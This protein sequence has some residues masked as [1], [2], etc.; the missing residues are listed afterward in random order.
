V[1][2]PA[3]GA[4]VPDLYVLAERWDRVVGELRRAGR[5]VL[6][7]LLAQSAPV[8]VAASGAVTIEPE[9]AGAA[10]PLEAARDDIVAALQQQF[11]GVQRVLVRR[12]PP[13]AEPAGARRV[14]HESVR[15]ERIGS[16]RKKDPVLGAAIDALDLELLE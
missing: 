12:P 1:A 15:S 7:T 5:G 8:A 10:D 6:A 4:A 13:S 11:A 14:T 9:D 2:G 3:G 16:L